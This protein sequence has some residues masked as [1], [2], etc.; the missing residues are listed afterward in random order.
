M[1]KSN[2]WSM[3]TLTF[4]QC[5]TYFWDTLERCNAFFKRF[6]VSDCLI[7]HVVIVKMLEGITTSG[8][9]GAVDKIS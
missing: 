5:T 1:S 7:L 4:W 6:N 8:E 2:R 3:P 9:T